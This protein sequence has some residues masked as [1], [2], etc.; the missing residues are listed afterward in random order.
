MDRFNVENWRNNIEDN[1]KSNTCYY[2]NK[3]IVNLFIVLLRLRKL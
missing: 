1:G 3:K 2:A